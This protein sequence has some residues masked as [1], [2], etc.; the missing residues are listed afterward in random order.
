MNYRL[1]YT[2]EARRS[3]RSL[4][5]QYRQRAKRIIEGLARRPR[6]AGVRELRDPPGVYRL[7]LNGWRIIHQIDEDAAIVRIVGVR[8][9]TG[10]ETYENLDVI[11][12]SPKGILYAARN[13]LIASNT[14]RISASAT[15]PMWAM[16]KVRPFRSP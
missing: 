7:Y 4:P 1:K 2:Q 9:K 12:E 11:Q 3:L 14:S 6:P 5:G 10:P 8:L 15:S 13:S 16:R